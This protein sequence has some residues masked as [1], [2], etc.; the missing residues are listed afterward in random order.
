LLVVSHTW[1]KTNVRPLV[2]AQAVDSEPSVVT[3]W[4][5]KAQLENGDD[6]GA[7]VG[8]EPKLVEFIDGV[9]VIPHKG[10]GVGIAMPERPGPIREAAIEGCEQVD[11]GGG[12]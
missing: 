6:R 3:V 1:P 4:D 11:V 8:H 10:V 2:Q 5:R 9:A 7:V 12:Q